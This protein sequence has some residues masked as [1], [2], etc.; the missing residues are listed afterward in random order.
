MENWCL[1]TNWILEDFYY[2]FLFFYSE[3]F[4][5]LF[6]VIHWILIDVI[7]FITQVFFL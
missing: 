5:A 4:G 2:V 1:S 6:L 3:L 7:I